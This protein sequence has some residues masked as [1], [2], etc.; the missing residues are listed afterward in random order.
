M[1]VCA[2][3]SLSYEVIFVLSSFAV[4]LL[5]KRELVALLCLSTWCR[6]AVIVICLFLT[7]LW[8]S[9]YCVCGHFLVILT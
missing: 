8:A 6:L 2:K 3:S 7:M 9:L 1:G 5:G 4:I